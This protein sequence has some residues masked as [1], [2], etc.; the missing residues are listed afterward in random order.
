MC[1]FRE[2]GNFLVQNIILPKGV[3]REATNT[4]FIVVFGLTWLGLECVIYLINSLSKITVVQKVINHTAFY[5]IFF[6]NGGFQLQTQVMSPGLAKTSY[7]YLCKM[8]KVTQKF[9]HGGFSYK[10]HVLLIWCILHLYFCTPKMKISDIC[11][12]FEILTI[13]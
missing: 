7:K 2:N 12:S 9:C 13:R 3:I 8:Y 10:L 11:W 1:V 4:N 6:L 5:V